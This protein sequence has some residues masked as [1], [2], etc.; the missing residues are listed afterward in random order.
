MGVAGTVGRGA[1]YTLYQGL[2]VC[3]MHEVEVECS[4]H[5]YSNDLTLRAVLRNDQNPLLSCY[6][7]TSSA[8]GMDIGIERESW[9]SMVILLI[10]HPPC[11]GLIGN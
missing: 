6:E 1:H 2:K 3:C 11:V 8:R 7:K 10:Q 9:W 5:Y 4:R